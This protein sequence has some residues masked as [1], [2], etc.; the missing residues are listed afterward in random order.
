MN[1]QSVQSTGQEG[2]HVL[3]WY[4]MR[5]RRREGHT[6]AEELETT[7]RPGAR[8]R[9][10]GQAGGRRRAQLKN[11][12]LGITWTSPFETPP[13]KAMIGHLFR[14]GFNPFSRSTPSSH[15]NYNAF[16]LEGYPRECRN[17]KE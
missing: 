11:P 10:S 15:L 16:L 5:S 3:W 8:R 14:V 1:V 17:E 7:Q 9:S 12:H 4:L 6:S 13:T 2:R